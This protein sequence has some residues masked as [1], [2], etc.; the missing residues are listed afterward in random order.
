MSSLVWSDALSLAMPVMDD[1]HREFV[2][3]LAEVQAAD[4]AALLARWQTLIDHTID[5]FGQ[6]DRWMEATG[7]APG[8]CHMTQHAVVLKVLKEGAE[9]GAQGNLAPIRQM[10]HELTIW[11]PHHAQ[12]MDAGLALH[13]KSV[14]YDPLTGQI[15]Q[16][17]ALPEQAISGCGGSCGGHGSD[18]EVAQE[19]SQQAA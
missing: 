8:S 19:E 13:L 15:A 6:E 14:G 3:L 11:F 5:H 17:E 16:P 4:D 1:T 12:T 10:A 9:L 7:F 18:A 2:D